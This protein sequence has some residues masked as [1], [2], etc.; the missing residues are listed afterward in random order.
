[1][2]MLPRPDWFQAMVMLL[3]PV[4]LEH[5]LLLRVHLM[6][7][8]EKELQIGLRG[9]RAAPAIGHSLE[10]DLVQPLVHANVVRLTHS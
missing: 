7:G 2:P 4:T 3:A 10:Y 5:F 8:I 6:Q 9:K 1:V